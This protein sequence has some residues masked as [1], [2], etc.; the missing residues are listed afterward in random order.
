MSD[1]DGGGVSPYLNQYT[2][3]NVYVRLAQ[4]GGKWQFLF[5]LVFCIEFTSLTRHTPVYIM[6]CPWIDKTFFIFLHRAPRVSH[7]ASWKNAILDIY[8]LYIYLVYYLFLAEAG[9][10]GG[11][12]G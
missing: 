2:A 3:A 8:I 11:S 12:S 6:W 9:R 1:D 5:F 10:P 4:C 7:R